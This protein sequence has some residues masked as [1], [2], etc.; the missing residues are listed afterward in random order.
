MLVTVHQSGGGAGCLKQRIEA[1]ADQAGE[2]VAHH[3]G[4]MAPTPRIVLTNGT[5]LST[6]LHRA[7][8]ELLG[9]VARSRSLKERIGRYRHERSCFGATALTRA[10]ALVLI[11]GARHHGNLRELDA[12]LL[13]E[14]AHA[15]QLGRPEARQLKITFMRMRYGLE[16]R[17]DAVR[18][19]M[20]RRLDIEEQQARNLEALAR[21][22]T[23]STETET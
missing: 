10:G 22:L 14:L 1:I 9:D 5:G 23:P 13:H 8:L 15:C 12:T 20:Y 4:G 16:S 11:N 18:A 2:L 6:L 21:R 3:L 7:D 17:D 19:A